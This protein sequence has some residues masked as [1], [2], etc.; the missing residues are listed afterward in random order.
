MP[1]LLISAGGVGK[2]PAMQTCQVGVVAAATPPHSGCTSS[3]LAPES[4]QM[5]LCAYTCSVGLETPGE[6]C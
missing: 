4:G 2:V 5:A 1:L 3:A 6:E